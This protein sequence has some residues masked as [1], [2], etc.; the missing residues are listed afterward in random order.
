VSAK[1]VYGKRSS[2]TCIVF[3]KVQHFFVFGTQ[4]DIYRK[5]LIDDLR[6]AAEICLSGI[7]VFRVRAAHRLL[8]SDNY[9]S[10]LVFVISAR[11]RQARIVFL[12]IHRSINIFKYLED[13]HGSRGG[14]MPRIQA[15]NEYTAERISITGGGWTDLV[16]VDGRIAPYRA[17]AALRR[18][19]E[20]EADPRRTRI[21]GDPASR[22][23]EKK[24]RSVQKRY[25]QLPVGHALSD[26][27]IKQP[28]LPP[29]R[30]STP[31]VMTRKVWSN[32]TSRRDHRPRQTKV[33]WMSISRREQCQTSQAVMLVRCQRHRSTPT[34]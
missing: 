33:N 4:P 25:L 28:S 16:S 34:P 20:T 17:S 8:T 29:V 30:T 31:A 9:E 19:N 13:Q 10:V 2:F 3:E 21:D 26:G 1:I 7:Q 27:F 32:E 24:L 18:I 23:R 11:T 12:T 5:S 6:R 15:L 22:K 14:S